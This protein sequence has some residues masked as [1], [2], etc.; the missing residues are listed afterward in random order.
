MRVLQSFDCDLFNIYMRLTVI[1]MTHVLVYMY[2]Y[3]YQ[4]SSLFLP[5]LRNVYVR[6]LSKSISQYV[7]VVYVNL[8]YCVARNNFRKIPLKVGRQF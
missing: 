3:P 8:V 5:L 6:V 4:T 2:M 1:C 7:H